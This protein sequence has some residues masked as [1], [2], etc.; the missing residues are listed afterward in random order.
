MLGRRVA[1]LRRRSPPGWIYDDRGAVAAR[2]EARKRSEPDA[3][4]FQ[5]L[6]AER[7]A[8]RAH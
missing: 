5:E 2:D 7:V 6:L 3:G 4:G 8:Q 1:A